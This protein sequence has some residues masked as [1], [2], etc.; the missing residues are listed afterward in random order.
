MPDDI[1]FE[2]PEYLLA[3]ALVG[4]AVLAGT[5]YIVNNPAAPWQLEAAYGSVFSAAGAAKVTANTTLQLPV[6]DAQ[7]LNRAYKDLN[8]VQNDGVGEQ[9]YC[10]SLVGDRL[11]V[12]Q[13]GTIEASESKVKYTLSNC[14]EPVAS[15]HYHPPG[16]EPVL[17]GPDTAVNEEFNDKRALLDSGLQFSCVQSGVT[18]TESGQRTAALRCYLPPESGYVGDTFPEIPVEIVAGG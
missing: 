17:S 4:V 5:V 6:E 3:A 14:I 12:Q 13:A 1:W 7:Y 15:L 16:S 8:Q 2:G 11:S 10:L 18:T 9:A